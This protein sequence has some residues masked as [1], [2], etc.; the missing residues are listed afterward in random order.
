MLKALAFPDMFIGWVMSFVTSVSYSIVINGYPQKSFKAK[1][2]LRQG[3]P[4]SPYLFTICMEYLSRLLGRVKDE[5]GFSYHPRCR[6][7][8]LTHLLFADD[9]LVFCKVDL[10]L[11][12]TI[13][14]SLDKFSASS[15]LV[16]NVAKSA[17]Y[18]AGV[19]ESEKQVI[20]TSLEMA[21]GA[22]QFRYLGVP[23]ASKKLSFGQ[24][25]PLVDAMVHRVRHWSSRLLSYAGRVVLV[26][27]VL[28]GMR[29]YWSQLFIFPKKLVRKETSTYMDFL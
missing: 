5:E 9:L 25:R 29:A 21:K 19:G 4:I 2:G 16:A 14:A 6:R 18:M 15:G 7:V 3:D 28:N 17:V 8:D 13:T 10:R 27:S 11:V 24:C 1:R 26:R 20:L 12:L 22:L 23:L